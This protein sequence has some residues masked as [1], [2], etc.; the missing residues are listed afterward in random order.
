MAATEPWSPPAETDT[1]ATRPPA[2]DGSSV[3]H[4]AAR[5]DDRR[6]RGL[7]LTGDWYCSISRGWVTPAMGRAEISRRN[8]LARTAVLMPA[9]AAGG[10]LLGQP[11]TAATRTPAQGLLTYSDGFQRADSSTVGDGWLQ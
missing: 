5:C 11:A 3:Q 10:A 7:P 8:F 6:G 2:L 1:T 4:P 9:V